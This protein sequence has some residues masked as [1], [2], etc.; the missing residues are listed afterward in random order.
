MLKE[1]KFGLQEAVCLATI[2]IAS[3][4]FYT[5]PGTVFQIVGTSGWYMTIVSALTAM[6]GFAF[7]LVLLRRFPGKGLAE[8]FE[9]SLGRIPG[10]FICAFFSFLF[11]Q[12]SAT[13]V[14]EFADVLRT[15]T[16][17]ETPTGLIVA[18]MVLTVS[19]S[20]AFG[21]ES[22]ARVAKLAGYLILACFVLVLV[23]ATQEYRLG[24]IFPILGYGLDKTVLTGLKR[25]SYYGSVVLLAFI[26]PSLQNLKSVKKAGLIALAI[27]GAVVSSALLCILLIFPYNI[28]QEL[29][30]PMYALARMVKYGYFFSRIDILFIF[31]WIVAS[32]I[33]MSVL[34]YMSTSIFCK[35]FRLT[36]LKPVVLPMTILLFALAM[37]PRDLSTVIHKSVEGSRS[38]NW[39][40]YFGLPLVALVTA[41]IRG[42]KGGEANA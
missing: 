10:F 26:A 35:A 38:F 34:L 12:E 36:A 31:I 6:A 7:V 41:A 18:T 24:N 4:V 32:V 9:L 30:D 5:S 25:S 28:G 39:I 21:L 29:T 16:F 3:K 42:K 23:L 33:C 8:I 19:V 1:G 37:L 15:Y 11:L 17:P 20:V 13:L 14:R 40:Y 22:L 2:A 27:S